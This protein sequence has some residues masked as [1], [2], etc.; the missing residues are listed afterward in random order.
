MGIA[1][2]V[3]TTI[4]TENSIGTPVNAKGA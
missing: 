2:I 1:W 3:F 4:P